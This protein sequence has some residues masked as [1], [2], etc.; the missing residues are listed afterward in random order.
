MNR[1]IVFT[2]FNYLFG[3]HTG[4]RHDSCINVLFLYLK[5]YIYSCKF[6]EKELRFEVFI[7]M[8]KSKQNVE[9]KIA[10]KKNKLNV[11]FKKWTIQL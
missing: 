9:Y 5:F 4:S 7:S 3:I 2:K 10:Q 1:D 11:H 8:V 6:Q